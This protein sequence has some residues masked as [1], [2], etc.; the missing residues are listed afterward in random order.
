VWGVPAGYH[1]EDEDRPCMIPRDVQRAVKGEELRPS[2]RL[3]RELVAETMRLLRDG[4]IERA[5]LKEARSAYRGINREA[6]WVLGN[7]AYDTEHIRSILN[8]MGVEA[9]IPVNPRSGRKPKPYDQPPTRNLSCDDV[10]NNK[11]LRN[12]RFNEL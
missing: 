10:S 2:I 11:G 6:Y 12:A 8:H 7:S 9:N 3:G 1:L 5:R 4:R